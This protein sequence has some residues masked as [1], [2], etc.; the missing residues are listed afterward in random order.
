MNFFVLFKTVLIKLKCENDNNSIVKNNII[1][2]SGEKF[3]FFSKLILFLF[4]MS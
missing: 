3:I 1:D 4:F 2:I